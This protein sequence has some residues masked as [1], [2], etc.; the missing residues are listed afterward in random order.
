MLNSDV[1]QHEHSM[2]I[3]SKTL[4][5][6]LQALVQSSSPLGKQM[7]VI[8]K[9]L[10]KIIKERELSYSSFLRYSYAIEESKSKTKQDYISLR[11]KVISLKD[12][13][14]NERRRTHG[15]KLAISKN[16][17]YIE[18]IVQAMIQAEQ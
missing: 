8:E 3:D 16:E 18:Q 7:D 5:Q 17:K 12:R 13:N 14:I 1:H 2:K 11:R 10:E 4:L 15:L 9:D 6:T